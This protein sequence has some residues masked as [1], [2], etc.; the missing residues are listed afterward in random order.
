MFVISFRNDGA[1]IKVKLFGV[2]AGYHHDGILLEYPV[3]LAEVY[4]R[5]EQ[6][7]APA[8]RPRFAIS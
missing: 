6:P 5:K 1:T 2:L 4:P 7:A 3:Q 8:L